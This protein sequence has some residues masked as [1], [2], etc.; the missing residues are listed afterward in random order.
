MMM[1][2]TISDYFSDE[3]LEQALRMEFDYEDMWDMDFRSV[4]NQITDEEDVLQL[5]L[6]SRI[7]NIDKITGGIEEVKV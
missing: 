7:F 4:F 6:R 2:N 1:T 3:D 5:K